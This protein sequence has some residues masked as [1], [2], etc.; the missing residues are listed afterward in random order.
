MKNRK[1]GLR[2]RP[3]TILDRR[4]FMRALGLGGL[5]AAALGNRSFSRAEAPPVRLVLWMT[6]HGTV[7]NH[8]NMTPPGL[9]SGVSSAS[10]VGL[11]DAS[12]SHILRPLRPHASWL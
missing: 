12:W 7:W 4:R 10:L 3:P 2:G 6:G 11:A 8:W 1:S 5:A 9:G